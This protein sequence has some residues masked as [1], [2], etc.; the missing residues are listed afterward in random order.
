MQQENRKTIVGAKRRRSKRLNLKRPREAHEDRANSERQ[1]CRL[2]EK[3]LSEEKN[4]NLEGLIFCRMEGSTKRAQASK[5]DGLD[6]ATLSVDSMDLNV[7]PIDCNLMLKKLQK[8]TVENQ[9]RIQRYLRKEL[10]NQSLDG[11]LV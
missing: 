2:C 7:V 11:L 3:E 9:L 1:Y 4:E 5:K 6:T 10:T 8:R